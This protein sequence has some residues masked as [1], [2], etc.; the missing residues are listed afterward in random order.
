MTDLLVPPIIID[1]EAS[2]FGKGS[3]PIEVGYVDQQGQSWCS[4]IQPEPDWQHWDSSAESVH[5]ISREIL[6]KHGRSGRDVA[7]H[8]NNS[9]RGQT[10][11]TDAWAHDYIWLSKLYDQAN[12]SPCFKLED[13]RF[14]LG[15]NQLAQW[16]QI[17]QQVMEELGAKR[18]RASTDARVLQM[19]W[20]RTAQLS[21]KD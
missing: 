17:K 11:Y 15:P 6:F 20:L 19:T 12:M 2:G 8:L 10:V 4:L 13:L 18:H 5:N 3:Y 9:L 21:D 7:V 16:H 1:L 14:R